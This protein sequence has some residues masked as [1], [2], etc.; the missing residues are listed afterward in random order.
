[1]PL[2]GIS[3]AK[4]D[5]RPTVDNPARSVLGG[6]TRRPSGSIYGGTDGSSEDEPFPRRVKMRTT[7]TYNAVMTSPLMTPVLQQ[8]YWALFPHEGGLTKGEVEM[9]CLHQRWQKD[10]NAPWDKQLPI[11]VKMGLCKRGNKR[12]CTA[13]NKEDATWVLTDSYTPVAPKAN[14]PS[15]KQYAKAVAQLE[16]I[17]AQ[18]DQ[19]GDG[20]VTPEL[21]KLYEWVRGK[22]AA[23][24]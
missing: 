4:L 23:P 9:A 22:V 5:V 20:M 18:H 19:R 7:E 24:G 16:T 1:M 15:A 8:V 14:K 6:D 13:K 10:P 21:R 3:T 17:M 11:L 2:G 12:H